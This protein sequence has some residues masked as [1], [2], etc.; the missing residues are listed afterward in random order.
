MDRPVET[1][2]VRFRI[3]GELKKRAEAVCART[4]MDLND[5]LRTLVRRI[6]TDGA[7]PFDVN[8]SGRVA[9]PRG[10]PY[11]QYGE[12]LTEDLAHLKAE[13]AIS[14]LASF[15]ADRAHRIATEKRKARPNRA[16]LKR[17]AAEARDAM[18]YR[19]TMNTRDDKLV[20][21]V[22]KKFAAL[23]AAEE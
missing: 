3:E 21:K 10:V 1:E 7:I 16:N 8:T 14:L 17:W 11:A 2:M 13:S 6:V 5:V 12:F 23:L 9:E 20:S 15:A 18:N 19:R 22:E 4:G